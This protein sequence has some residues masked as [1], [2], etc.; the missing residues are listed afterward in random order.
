M[1][2]YKVLGETYQKKHAIDSKIQRKKNFAERNHKN[3][4]YFA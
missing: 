1:Q 3:A 4:I 2:R